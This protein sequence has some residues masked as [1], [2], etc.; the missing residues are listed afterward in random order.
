MAHSHSLLLWRWEILAVLGSAVAVAG[1]AILLAALDGHAV[2]SWKG[3]TLNTL[4][5]LLSTV[6][7][8]LL[9]YAVGE[10]ISQWKWI[11]FSRE[12]RALIDFQHIG[13]AVTGP[14]GSL[15]LIFSWGLR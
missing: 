7:K 9:L 15:R 5:S 3:V 10:A 13:D 1:M 14:L 8:G 12:S 11:V 2:F 4:V 6:S